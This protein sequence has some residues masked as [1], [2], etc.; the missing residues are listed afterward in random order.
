LGADRL[1]LLV[2]QPDERAPETATGLGLALAALGDSF[3]RHADMQLVGNA[4]GWV[5]VEPVPAPVG[6]IA[7]RARCTGGFGGCLHT[8]QFARACRSPPPRGIEPAFGLRI[9]LARVDE[10]SYLP[11]DVFFGR[12]DFAGV[13]FSVWASD[14]GRFFPA[15]SG[16]FRW[17]ADRNRMT[18]AP[19]S[20]RTRPWRPRPVSWSRWPC[21]QSRRHVAVDRRQDLSRLPLVTAGHHHSMSS[22][23]PGPT[24]SGGATKRERTS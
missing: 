8:L 1:V 23:S 13:F 17:S 20:P 2:Q 14:F 11:R 16:S 10:P 24:M 18:V 12:L 5:P 6:L 19:A 9:V 21:L 7:P 3:R 15:T 4:V 22:L